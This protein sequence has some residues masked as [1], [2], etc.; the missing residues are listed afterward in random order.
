MSRAQVQ[1][2]RRTSV[3]AGALCICLLA[4][5]GCQG[6]APPVAPRG[7]APGPGG[8]GA[9]TPEAPPLASNAE[10]QRILVE[11]VGSEHASYGIVVGVVEPTGRRVVSHGSF[12]RGD[13]RALGGDTVF[14]IGSITKVFTSLLLA[15][16]ALRGEVSLTDPVAKFLPGSVTLPMR[17]GQAITLQH[18][19]THTSGLPRLPGNIAPK[20][21]QNPYADYS[22]DQ[23]YEFLSN[24]EL[25]RD[26]GA[27]AEYSNLGAGLLGH[28]LE[29]RTGMAYED[30]VRT[31][32]TEPLGMHSTAV[33]LSP[34]L[35]A[36]LAPGHTAALEV[37]PSW[38]LPTLAGA[39]A[40][41]ST[42]ND[43]LTFLEAAL[44]L[45]ETPLSRAFAATLQLQ[46]PSGEG[47]PE[48]LLGWQLYRSHG[49]EIIW[50]N[51]GTGGYRAVIGFDP[52]A[53]Q[54]V[55]VWSN[56]STPQGT[57]DLGLHLLD[58]RAP[59]GTSTPPAR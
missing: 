10:I 23:L 34:E 16:A 4:A 18:L 13:S 6:N 32:I 37:A 33:T 45:T 17:H 27:V 55:V 12:S 9:V 58:P 42:A 59:L 46:R 21:P 49:K 22:L 29:L 35:R 53:R 15:D 19:A 1:G 38:D 20:D 41:R 57:D 31:R 36:R 48:L 25:R 47:G 3:L 2:W 5:L 56:V 8:P 30:L 54:G 50:H 24:V 39:G 7:G 28:A 11:R 43:L 51:G 44:G 52:K 40:L 26:I 14:E